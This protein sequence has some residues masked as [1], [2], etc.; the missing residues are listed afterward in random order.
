MQRFHVFCNRT[1]YSDDLR[2]EHRVAHRAIMRQAH[3][4]SACCRAEEHFDLATHFFRENP[5]AD[6][7]EFYAA[8]PHFR[9]EISLACM[10][11]YHVS[12]DTE[13]CL[14]GLVAVCATVFVMRPVLAT[15][16]FLTPTPTDGFALL[17]NAITYGPARPVATFRSLPPA[18]RRAAW[19]LAALVSHATRACVRNKSA[20]RGRYLHARVVAWLES[21]CGSLWQTS[22][23]SVLLVHEL[24]AAIKRDHVGRVRSAR[25]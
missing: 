3:H 20:R 5:Q 12:C 14:R 8:I 4:V 22:V 10:D 25:R 9:S 23:P 21:N 17:F 24:V 7:T 19:T 2:V 13:L 6:M 11:F 15:A 1:M 16:V 18:Q